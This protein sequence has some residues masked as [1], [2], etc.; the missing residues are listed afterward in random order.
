MRL[1]DDTQRGILAA[2]GAGLV[3]SGQISGT[4]G[5]LLLLAIAWRKP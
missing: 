1:E 2:V 5:G 4:I 3:L